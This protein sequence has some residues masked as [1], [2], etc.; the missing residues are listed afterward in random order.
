MLVLLTLLTA[1]YFAVV[2]R[3]RR[4]A[5][6]RRASATEPLSLPHED[7]PPETAVGWPPVGAAFSAYVDEGFRAL[8][9][10]LSEGFAT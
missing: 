5:K 1:G 10:Y 4:E 2:I 6:R 8:D 3:V 7:L 9:A